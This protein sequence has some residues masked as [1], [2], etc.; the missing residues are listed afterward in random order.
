[1]FF[2]SE[3]DAPN[4]YPNS[5]GGPEPDLKATEPEFEVSGTVTRQPYKHP[6]SDFVQPGNL[7]RL[8][9]SIDREHLTSNIVTHLQN[10]NKDIQ[11]R[12]AQIF[13]KADHEYGQHVAEGL[14]ITL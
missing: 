7:Y 10:A 6:N 2:E 13:Y 5:F 12:Q 9:T 4:Y 14:S 3:G 1:M 11:L 8:M